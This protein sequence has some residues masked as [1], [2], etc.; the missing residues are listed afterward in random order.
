MI[1]RLDEGE[2]TT[3][4]VSLIS[5]GVLA[6]LPDP[7]WASNVADPPARAMTSLS[8]LMEEKATSKAQAPLAAT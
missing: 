1:A 3:A 4:A 2:I 6:T 5:I 8:S 7:P